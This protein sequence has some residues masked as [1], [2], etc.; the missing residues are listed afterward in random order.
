MPTQTFTPADYPRVEPVDLGRE[1][2][3][4]DMINFFVTFMATD[5]LGRIAVLHQILADQ[6]ESGTLSPDCLKLA[7]MH[8]TAVDYSKTGISVCEHMPL[9]FHY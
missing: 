6:N 2:Q 4:D 7:D 5:Q 8:S 3:K 9:R 1:V